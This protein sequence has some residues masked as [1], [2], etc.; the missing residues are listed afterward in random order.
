[1][2]GERKAPVSLTFS[3][4]VHEILNGFLGRAIL[5]NQKASQYS[6]SLNVI[7]NAYAVVLAHQV[8]QKL[9]YS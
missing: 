2:E 4:L 6:V 3:L 1:M 8:S 7:I 5:V 9:F